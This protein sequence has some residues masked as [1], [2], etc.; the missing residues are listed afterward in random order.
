LIRERDGTNPS[1]ACYI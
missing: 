1:S